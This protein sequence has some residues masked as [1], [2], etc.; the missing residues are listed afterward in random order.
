MVIDA[1]AAASRAN[2]CTVHG[3]V[4]REGA[5]AAIA[6]IAM[7]ASDGGT[8][9]VADADP[10]LRGLTLVDALQDLGCTVIT[11]LAPDWLR[12][13]TRATTGVTGALLGVAEQ[14]VVA[15][16]AGRDSPRAASLLPASH[17]CVVFTDTVLAT[18]A[19]AVEAV[20]GVP[21][22]S[23]LTWVGGPSRTGDLEMIQTLG[24]HGPK[25]VHM[26]L[27]EP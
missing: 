22:P 27:V 12:G 17:V 9:A 4:T 5:A 6:T 1:F 25:T 24:V 10:A 23:A 14:G 18:F 26:V 13:L 19:A 21:L 20:A 16:A 3:P 2:S 7:D 15:L 11:P 8:I